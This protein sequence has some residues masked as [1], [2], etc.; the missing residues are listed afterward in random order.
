MIIRWISDVPSKMVKIFAVGAVSAGQT[1]VG[2]PGISTDSARPVRDEF[3]FWVG[4]E[5]DRRAGH[6]CAQSEDEDEDEGGQ[7]VGGHPRCRSVRR[8]EDAGTSEV[9]SRADLLLYRFQD[10]RPCGRWRAD[11]PHVGRTPT[12]RGTLGWPPSCRHG[13][14]TARTGHDTPALAVP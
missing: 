14:V 5:R 11:R 9:Y 3:R 8:L 1:P 2:P 4:P 12:E 13:G 10:T 7:E 6:G